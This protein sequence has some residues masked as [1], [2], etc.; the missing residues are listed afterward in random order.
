MFALYTIVSYQITRWVNLYFATLNFLQIGFSSSF[1]HLYVKKKER[2]ERVKVW[3]EGGRLAGRQFK[4]PKANT[5]L[6]KDIKV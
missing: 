4:T 5:I 1:T 6:N 3:E 2:G